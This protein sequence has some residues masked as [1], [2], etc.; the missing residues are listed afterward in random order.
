MILPPFLGI[1]IA[2]N[3]P[4][5]NHLTF[6]K[7]LCIIPKNKFIRQFVTILSLNKTRD[8]MGAL[9]SFFFFVSDGCVLRPFF[10]S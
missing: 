5:C 1:I 3:S 6:Y 8:L 2:E 7:F 9:H 10:F 4:D